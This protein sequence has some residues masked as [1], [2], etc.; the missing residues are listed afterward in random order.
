MLPLTAAATLLAIRTGAEQ[1]A[2]AA[3]GGGAAGVL[4]CGD[5]VALR[6]LQPVA[7]ERMPQG[8]QGDAGE[9][10]S[11]SATACS[12]SWSRAFSIPGI[13]CCACTERRTAPARSWRTRC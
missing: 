1:G 7:T 5:E 6:H 9:D 4:Q 11:P 10:A 8:R 3:G 13:R 12:S 2:L